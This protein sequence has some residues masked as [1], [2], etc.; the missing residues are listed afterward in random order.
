[1]WGL[2]FDLMTIVQD[3]FHGVHIILD[4]CRLSDKPPKCLLGGENIG[5]YEAGQTGRDG[6]ASR[7][8]KN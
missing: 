6:K 1:M 2:L 8:S 3:A 7:D 4:F 5:E